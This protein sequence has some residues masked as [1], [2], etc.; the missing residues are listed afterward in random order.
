MRFEWVLGTPQ[1]MTRVDFKT[2]GYMYGLGTATMASDE[3]N[4]FKSEACEQMGEALLGCL[5]K[6]KG[7]DNPCC[8]AL[9]N[10][11]TRWCIENEAIARYI[12]EQPGPSLRFARFSDVLIKFAEEIKSDTE[13]KIA[14]SAGRIPVTE[15]DTTMLETIEVILGR[16]EA[17]MQRFQP[18]IDEQ[19]AT[20]ANAGGFNGYHDDFQRVSA[21]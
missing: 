3:M 2:K 8:T 19:L 11:V 14:K 16:R 21:D 6:N 9:L 12:F 13:A 17:L 7:R 10:A 1:L 20:L 5:S 4:T 18:W 15:K